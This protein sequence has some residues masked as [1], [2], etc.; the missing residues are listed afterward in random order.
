MHSGRRREEVQIKIY[1]QFIY[2][3][4]KAAT[5]GEVAA[6]ASLGAL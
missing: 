3:E 6:G 5:V 1:R 2:L 4:V